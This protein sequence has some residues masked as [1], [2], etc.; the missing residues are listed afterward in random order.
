MTEER[1]IKDIA[2]LNLATFK[3]GEMPNSIY[4]L[5]TGN[6][7]KNVIDELKY[8]NLSK[9]KLPSRAQRKIKKGS[10]V[11]STVRPNQE[12][13]GY[14]EEDEKELV[15]STGF[16]TIDV[17]ED[18]VDSK[19]L[20][21][22]LT[23]SHITEYLHN[24]GMNSVSSYPSIS[25]ND[26][27]TLKFTFPIIKTQKAIAKVLSDLDS[28]IELNNR[29]NKKLE[30]MAKLIYDYWFVQFDFPNENGKPYKSSGGKMVYSEELKREIPEGWEVKSLSNIANYT[31]GIAC[32]KYR[33]TDD[34]YL[35]VIKIKEMKEGF[36]EKTEKVKLNIPE[37][38]KVY[39]GDIL[40][41]WSA[42]LEVVLW[43]GGIGALNQHIFKVTSAEMP[44]YYLYFELLNYLKH[45]KMI[46][47]LRKTT[48]GHITSDHLKQSRVSIAKP[49]VIENFN[50]GITPIIDYIIKN[51]IQNQKLKE[52]RDWLLPMLMNGQ[53]RVGE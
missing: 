46:A 29:I 53:V 18:K 35:R 38:V 39:N 3:K 12:H 4:Y 10:I 40:F 32:Q 43:T 19:Y 44:K 21:Y 7:T 20:F 9:D 33:P 2:V 6:I 14:F 15:V 13:Y 23:Q 25:P 16:T 11:Y 8:Y 26:I 48:M 1:L 22:L 37:K 51:Q 52:T 50:K 5:D 45:F 47:E 34:N 42:S 36:S 31:N 27:G 49:D 24:V 41:S 28:K 17:V 30:E